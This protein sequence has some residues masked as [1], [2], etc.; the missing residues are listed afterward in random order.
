M[1]A[2]LAFGPG[3][4]SFVTIR[5]RQ[6]GQITTGCFGRNAMAGPSPQTVRSHARSVRPCDGYRRSPSTQRGGSYIQGFVQRTKMRLPSMARTQGSRASS[7]AQTQSTPSI[8]PFHTTK[9]LEKQRKGFKSESRC[10]ASDATSPPMPPRGLDPCGEVTRT[11]CPDGGT[12]FWNCLMHCELS[13][14]V[15][16]RVRR[17]AGPKGGVCFK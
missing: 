11:C 17:P 3:L 1:I 10:A 5:R 7:P 9:K 16:S 2:L 13:K 8:P 6:R 4:Y 12:C 14:R 15:A